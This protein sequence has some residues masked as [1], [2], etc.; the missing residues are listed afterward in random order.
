MQRRLFALFHTVIFLIESSAILYIIE[1]GLRQRHDRKR[2]IAIGLVM[3]ESAVYVGDGRVCPITN[4]AREMG[5][6][7]IADIFLP[8][9]FAPLIPPICRTLTVFWMVLPFMEKL[10]RRIAN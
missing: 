2:S 5:D 10:R 6:D 1:S 3:A 7:L 4:M 8:R 9:W